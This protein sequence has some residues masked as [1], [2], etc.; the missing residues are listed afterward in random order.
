MN[1]PKVVTVL[2]G[3]AALYFAFSIF[4]G[5]EA[6][7]STLSTLNWIFFILALIGCVDSLYKLAKGL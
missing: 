6:P 3:A 4:G 5:T 1:N 2:S 7:S